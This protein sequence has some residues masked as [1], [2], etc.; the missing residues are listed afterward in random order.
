MGSLA[1]RHSL[2]YAQA[3][4]RSVDVDRRRF[5]VVVDQD[6]GARALVQRERVERGSDLTDEIAPAQ[7]VGE[8]LRQISPGPVEVG[9][10]LFS[11]AYISKAPEH[12]RRSPTNLVFCAM[13]RERR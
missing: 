12:V 6:G 8:L 1:L 7:L 10:L 4:C 11:A 3:V 5:T 9:Y 13:L 2:R